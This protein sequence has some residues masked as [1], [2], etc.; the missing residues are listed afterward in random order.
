MTCLYMR[1]NTSNYN[2]KPVKPEKRGHD[3]ASVTPKTVS[4]LAV[5]SARDLLAASSEIDKLQ[6]LSRRKMNGRPPKEVNKGIT[7]K[8]TY[9]RSANSL[10]TGGQSISS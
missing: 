6:P 4:L 9:M 8:G 5:R 2:R 1:S 3:A 10:T 7:T